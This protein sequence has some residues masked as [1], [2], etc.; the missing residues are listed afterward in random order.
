MDEI[1]FLQARR[2]QGRTHNIIEKA[3]ASRRQFE[4]CEELE[5]MSSLV[6]GLSI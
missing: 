2:L 4:S 5:F 6:Q 1:G 3:V